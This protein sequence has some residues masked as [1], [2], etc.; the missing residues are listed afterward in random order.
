MLEQP[1]CR[2]T[3]PDTQLLHTVYVY[4]I[5]YM[6]ALGSMTSQPIPRKGQHRAT[7]RGAFSNGRVQSLQQQSSAPASSLYVLLNIIINIW[8][9]GKKKGSKWG[10]A[11][12]TVTSK[13]YERCGTTLTEGMFYLLFAILNV[14]QSSAAGHCCAGWWLSL[15]STCILLVGSASREAPH[16]QGWQ[17]DQRQTLPSAQ[18]HL[19]LIQVPADGQHLLCWI[20]TCSQFTNQLNNYCRENDREIHSNLG[21]D[22]PVRTHG[23]SYLFVFFFLIRHWFCPESLF[24]W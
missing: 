17:Q 5:L 19:L 4:I 11:I 7:R 18:Q 1:K 24:H 13:E 9:G 15:G 20:T 21:N 12:A 6:P 10:V 3:A 14:Q 23:F 2:S 16:F 8:R 22:K